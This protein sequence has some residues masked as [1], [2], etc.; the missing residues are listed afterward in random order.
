MKSK[1]AK[2][3][4]ELKSKLRELGERIDQEYQK[5]TANNYYAPD[6]S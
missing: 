2:I 3:L 4:V 6:L 5:Y 1:K